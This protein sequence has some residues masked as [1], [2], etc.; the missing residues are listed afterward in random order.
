MPRH[1]AEGTYVLLVA[2]ANSYTHAHD[3]DLISH[4]CISEKVTGQVSDCLRANSETRV[5]KPHGDLNSKSKP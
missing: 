5:Y 2:H 3:L 4:I 1:N